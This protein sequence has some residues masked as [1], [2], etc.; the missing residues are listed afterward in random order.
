MVSRKSK[1]TPDEKVQIVLAGLKGE[2]PLTELCHR[3]GIQPT[4]YYQWRD[5]LP[6]GGGRALE[7]RG[8]NDHAQQ[9]EQRI[10]ELERALGKKT[11]DLEIAGNPWGCSGE[12][13]H[14]DRAAARP[15]R[16]PPW[17]AGGGRAARRALF[18][19]PEAAAPKPA[20]GPAHGGGGRAVC[21]LP[22][23]RLP[24]HHSDDPP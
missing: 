14:A 23:V 13:A 16:R 9:L 15:R 8:R 10:R 3:H 24:P 2:V 6:E 11:L 1:Y 4:L 12:T 5:R 18:A 17:H 7:G 19:V 20:I 22:A 21:T